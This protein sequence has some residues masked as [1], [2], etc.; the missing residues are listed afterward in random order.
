MLGMG[1]DNAHRIIVN[2]VHI[3][4]I[5]SEDLRK[6]LVRMKAQKIIFILNTRYFDSLSRIRNALISIQGF[7]TFES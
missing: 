3:F 2:L 6:K 5:L 4:D 1:L 7:K